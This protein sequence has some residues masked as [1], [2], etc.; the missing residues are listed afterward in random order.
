MNKT[1]PKLKKTNNP[2]ITLFFVL[3]SAA[4]YTAEG[5]CYDFT[6]FENEEL[7]MNADCIGTRNAGLML[8]NP[9]QCIWGPKILTF[10][11]PTGEELGDSLGIEYLD[12]NLVYKV[13]NV[14]TGDE[15]YGTVTVV[16][17]RGP[18]IECENISLPCTE[19]YDPVSIGTPAAADNCTYVASLSH[20][21]EVIDFGCGEE[22]FTGYFAPEN[23]NECI[24]GSTGDGGV[25]V[26][27]APNS[28]SVEGADDSPVSDNCPYV[29][30]FKIELPAEG[31][32]SFDWSSFGGS[33]FDHENAFFTVGDTC[34][35]L[36]IDGQTSGSYTSWLIEPGMWISFEVTSNGDA[37]NMTAIFENFRFLTPAI[38]VIHRTWTGY[39]ADANEGSCTQVITLERASLPE[40][41]FP[42]DRDGVAAPLIECG[43]ATDP[44]LTEPDAVGY[45][46]LD[47]D[48]DLN[49][50]DDQSLFVG[51]NECLLDVF[52]ND[53]I[54]PECDGNYTILRTWTVLDNCT[55]ETR[56]EIQIIRV[57]DTMPP[58]LACPTDMTV[59]TDF[60][61]CTA[62]FPV[63]D[64]TATDACSND[65]TYTSS[66]QFGAGQSVYTVTPGTH[67]LTLSASDA[68]GNTAECT[69]NVTVADQVA[70]T[71]VCDAFTTAAV[72]SEGVSIVFAESIDDGSYDECCQYAELTY[73]VKLAEAP[74]TDYAPTVTFDC[75]Y[76][77]ESATVHMRVTDCNGNSNFCTT[78][79]AVQDNTAPTIAC[80]DNLT[81]DCGTDLSDLS[82]F[83]T[84]VGTDNCAFAVSEFVSQ[85][86]SSCGVGTV[87]RVF[88]INDP[89]GNTA[90]CTQVISVENL[91]P[92]NA[93]GNAISFPP[94]YTIESECDTNVQPADLPAPFDFPTYSDVD[95][96]E[97]PAV[98]FEDEIFYISEPACYYILRTWSVMD[99]CGDG[100]F[101][102]SVQ[103]ITVNDN[104]PPVFTYPQTDVSI[105]LNGANNCT[106]N[107]TLTPPE[108]SD[109][110]P[111]T[112]VT[113]SGDLGTTFGTYEDVPAGVYTVIYTATDG[114]GNSTEESFTVNVIDNT[115][116]TLNCPADVTVDCG[117]DLTDL[118]GYG[119]PTVTESCDAD[120]YTVTETAQQ[121]INA[122]GT[123]FV[124]RI[125]TITDEN[126]NTSICNQFIYLENLTPWNADG[127]AVTFPADYALAGDCNMGTEPENLPA[128]YAFPTWTGADA[129]AQITASFT[130]ETVMI[131]PPNCF[132]INRTWIVSDMCNPAVVYTD[133]QQIMVEDNAA[134]VFL[135]APA[136]QLLT[137]DNPADCTVSVNIFPPELD[138]CDS[139]TEVIL[140]G[141]LMQGFGTYDLMPGIYSII[142]TAT[143]G[144][145]NSAEHSYQITVTD[146]AP[147]TAICLS[148]LTLD[149][150]ESQALTVNAAT[151][152]A[153]SND[154]CTGFP[155][156]TFSYSEDTSDQTLL[157][158]CD[159]LGNFTADLYVT[160]E[161]GNQSSCT[162]SVQVNDDENNCGGTPPAATPD[163]MGQ[164]FT[165][166]S[167]PVATA[168]ISLENTT[169]APYLTGE[170][171]IYAFPDMTYGNDYVMTPQKNVN[172]HN[173]VTTLDVHIVSDHLN[174]IAALDNPYQYIAADADRSDNLAENDTEV[175][176]D[177]IL[178]NIEEFPNNTSWRFTQADYIFPN[179]A[180]PWLQPFPE[181]AVITD[182]Q[183]D[184][185]INFIGIK[186]GDVNGTADP[187]NLTDDEG[188]ERDGEDLLLTAEDIELTAGEDYV[189]TL[190]ASD[191]T[192]FIA[193]QFT[194]DFAAEVLQ[195]N[196]TEA[197]DLEER[198]KFGVIQLPA[199][200][201]TTLWYD[202]NHAALTGEQAVFKLHLTAL[203]DGKLSEYLGISSR[204]TTALSY[205]KD[206]SEAGVR[207]EFR[208]SVTEE[209]PAAEAITDFALYGNHPN[210]FARKTVLNFAVP[211]SDSEVTFTFFTADGKEIF[212]HTA[213]YEKGRQR[214]E[215]NRSDLGLD[216]DA[217]IL[218]RMTSRT[219]NAA[220][221]MVFTRQQQ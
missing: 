91:T 38:K 192:D 175:I 43:D 166:E 198:I 104:T 152:N 136:T 60:T 148:G 73:E 33:A 186:T 118:S 131:A 162:V 133:V 25:D 125:W 211:Q 143:D 27:G 30:K 208:E 40:V 37:D 154:N 165:W 156:L 163:L 6:C 102:T 167:E 41:F 184:Q 51:G 101:F 18:D 14:W 187:V 134:P 42:P 141:D 5:Q 115:V 181:S 96:C 31:Y 109:C 194:I 75:G 80:P 57:A 92:W 196:G 55:E 197:A 180:N 195:I 106:A 168:E 29:T 113:V 44:T 185:I 63:P 174:D 147:P 114:C 15:C 84:A 65:L 212:A 49:T 88:E 210:P 81:I 110:S 178:H 4:F 117:T 209:E 94:D 13:V 130:D 206:L 214:L 35:Q 39:D 159:D 169:I 144:C 68:C 50:T 64:F 188:E 128:P 126:G 129:C 221:K 200:A 119:M 215:I 52:H 218:Y 120:T 135:N 132:Q 3:L 201:L 138:E 22:G 58:V 28:I 161:A 56:E 220:G 217:L 9:T 11:S 98:N 32:I 124:E 111:D 17:R 153:A 179:A 10:Y 146:D 53:V 100:T 71:V 207:L 170:T 20:S 12:M 66:W 158:T 193:Y 19:S 116:P 8:V 89:A 127:N 122:C 213:N 77:G 199:G 34:V 103:T 74:I 155:N 16:D 45:P 172:P 76:T 189:V 123:G 36:T 46:F 21:D 79:V 157:L 82:V 83:G 24:L 59:S 86:L 7:A 183:E 2:F 150:P 47:A 216:T 205:R 173:G 62:T 70:P 177:M 139:G 61:S 54:L 204:F 140:T 108:V 176:E 171:G 151:L 112:E 203:A 219:F 23:W 69:V 182:L 67:A 164:V 149:I 142:Y 87:T 202:K 93:D 1:L 121:T 99:W 26:T 97:Q 190:T 85:D 191:L 145:G 105:T 160:D 78:E 137:P 107:V 90:S 95:G 72:T 48:G